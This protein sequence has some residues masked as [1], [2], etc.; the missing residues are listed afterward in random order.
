MRREGSVKRT[1]Q[2]GA[3]NCAWVLGPKRQVKAR[4]HFVQDNPSI[5]AR[6]Q[7]SSPTGDSFFN[8]LPCSPDFNVMEASS[9]LA[10]GPWVQSDLDSEPERSWHNS[11][12]GSLGTV[13]RECG[14][15]ADKISSASTAKVPAPIINQYLSHL[16]YID[17]KEKSVKT[18]RVGVAQKDTYCCFKAVCS[19]GGKEWFEQNFS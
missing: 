9:Y 5:K 17:P 12:M 4:W 15:N 19:Q 14:V 6:N 10:K 16:I 7:W 18:S 2:V 3:A 13:S 8:H 1:R 11:G